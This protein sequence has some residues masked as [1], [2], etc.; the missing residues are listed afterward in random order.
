MTIMLLS[1]LSTFYPYAIS[2]VYVDNLTINQEKKFQY[3]MALIKKLC[4]NISELGKL[5]MKKVRLRAKDTYRAVAIFNIF[6]I[7]FYSIFIGN[8]SVHGK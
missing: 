8:S 7:A 4:K 3:L 5:S 2:K 6:F 1:K